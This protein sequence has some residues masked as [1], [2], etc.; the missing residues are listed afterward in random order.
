MIENTVWLFYPGGQQ[1]PPDR[2]TLEPRLE[3]VGIYSCRKTGVC[4]IVYVNVFNGGEIE[5]EAKC[6]I[7][8]PASLQEIDQSISLRKLC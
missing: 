2:I 3:E 4:V 8:Q 5:G 6:A 1:I 7:T